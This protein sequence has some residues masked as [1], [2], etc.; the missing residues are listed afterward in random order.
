MLSPRPPVVTILILMSATLILQTGR[1]CGTA[2]SRAHADQAE[3]RIYLPL[4]LLPSLEADF[5]AS[6]TVGLAPL[7]VV[8]TNTST[9]DYTASGWNFGDSMTSTLRNPT[10]T[11]AT[12]GAYTVTLTVSM[13][14]MSDT[15]TRTNYIT[16]TNTLQNGSFEDE[17]WVDL[18]P[19]PGNLINQQPVGWTLSWVEI[20]EPLY[21]STDPA[22]GVPECVHKHNDQLP[23]E[24]QLGGPEALVLDGNYTYKIFHFGAPFGAELTQ[25]IFPLAA[26]VSWRLTVPI[27]LDLHGDTDP[28]GAE[29]G[30]WVNGVGG[31]ANAATMGHR[32]WYDHVVEFTPAAG[33]AEIV[34]RVK[35]KHARK[36]FFIDN[37]RLEMVSNASQSQKSA[38]EPHR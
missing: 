36:D 29:S 31:W 10:H 6:P 1:C 11:Y 4:V 25:T 3:S 23:L 30:V 7:T 8:F 35:D 2:L 33:Q 32:N 14:N 24:E 21:D 34:I 15:L 9:G 5:A 22:G 17:N 12:V 16:V 13:V 19:E 20:G 28:W 38:R 26:G 37:I 27:L 18:P